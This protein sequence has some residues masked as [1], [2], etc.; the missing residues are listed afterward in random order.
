MRF[1]PPSADDG[2]I[3]LEHLRRTTLGDA[4]LEREVLEMFSRQAIR[5]VGALAA[6]PPDADALAHTL[7]GSARAI[8]ALRVA[9][10][11]D[12][13]EAATSA[14]GDRAKALAELDAAVA[15]ACAAI[16]AILSRP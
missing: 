6:M 4:G 10:R 1:P 11:A 14:G 8:G 13:F 15:E 3:D 9:D 2:S 7:K 16:V 12:A 5:L